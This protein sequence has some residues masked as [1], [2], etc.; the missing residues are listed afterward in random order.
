MAN[1]RPFDPNAMNAAMLEVPL[2]TVVRI[3]LAENPSRFI[4]VTI[5]DRGPYV[6]GRIID[7]TKTAFKALVGSTTT[8]LVRATVTIPN[9]RADRR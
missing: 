6:A 9:P 2:G 7:L 3:R 1:G 8:G 5:T 4:T